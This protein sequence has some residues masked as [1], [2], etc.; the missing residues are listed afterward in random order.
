MPCERKGIAQRLTEIGPGFA[1]SRSGDGGVVPEGVAPDAEIAES[2]LLR[3]E[4]CWL[5]G[6]HARRIEDNLNLS[7]AAGD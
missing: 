5:R 2:C 6:E 4:S 1:P 7:A 3:V